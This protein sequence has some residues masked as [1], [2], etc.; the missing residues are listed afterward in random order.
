MQPA[1]GITALSRWHDDGHDDLRIALKTSAERVATH[2]LGPPNKCLSNRR[3]LRWGDT[4]RVRVQI[5]GRDAGRWIE[6]GNGG[7]KGD[8]LAM[9]RAHNPMPFA[10]VLA[11]TY[12]FVGLQPPSKQ[13]PV[14][15]RPVIPPKPVDPAI[16][17]EHLAD[18]A[19]RTAA[20]Q[21]RWNAGIPITGTIAET[22]LVATRGFPPPPAGW[23]SVAQL[24]YHPT[25]RALMAP[26]IGPNGT[27]QAVA[28]IYLDKNGQKATNRPKAKQNYGPMTDARI[29]LPGRTGPVNLAEGLETGLAAWLAT[30]CTTW[31]TC[32]T[33]TRLE[34]VPKW[35]VALEDDDN[36]TD[37]AEK[38]GVDTASAIAKAM[39][40]WTAAGSNVVIARPWP[41]RRYDG[42]DLA[43]VMRQHGP[44]AVK[45]RINIAV[46]PGVART[47]R[48]PVGEARK[49]LPSAMRP[50]FNAGTADEDP[51]ADPERP[52][53]VYVVHGS[54]GLGKSHETR[55]QIAD[56]INEMRRYGAKRTICVAVPRHDL[57]DQ[58][59]ERLRALDPNLY[60]EVWQ[61]RERPDPDQ[62]GQ[63]MCRDME[64][65]REAS[66]AQLDIDAYACKPC[67]HRASCGY[68]RQKNLQGVDVWIVAHS[69]L[70]NAK[71]AA[72]KHL[73]MLVIDENPLD[74]FLIGN[75][76]P[77][78]TLP[79]D[80]FDHVPVIEHDPIGTGELRELWQRAKRIV[81]PE[82]AEPGPLKRQAFQDGG[83]T[84][85][86][87]GNAELL[88][89]ATLYR[90]KLLDSMSRAER[91]TEIKYAHRNWDLMRRVAFWKAVQDL[92]DPTINTT[93][94]SGH[95][96]L[97]LSD[98]D[99]PRPVIVLKRRKAVP[100]SWRVPTLITTATLKL[101]LLRYVWPQIEVSA[102]VNITSPHTRIRQV[103][104]CSYSMSRLDPGKPEGSKYGV[105]NPKEAARR[106]N[107]RRDLHATIA[108][109]ARAVFPQKVLVVAQMAVEAELKALGW[110]PPN[111]CW[112]HHNAMTGLD[113]Y[114]DAR[115]IIVIGRTLPRTSAVE[116]AA[117]ALT[118]EAVEH[119]KQYDMADAQ[120]ETTE[121]FM[122]ATETYRHPNAIAEQFRESICE[123][124][125]I[126]IIGRGRGAD[127]TYADPL[128]VLV[129][130]D[131]PLD[132]PVAEFI[133]AESLEPSPWDLQFAAG[134]IAYESPA[135]AAKAYPTLWRKDRAAE[136]AFKEYRETLRGAN[137]VT[138]H[139]FPIENLYMGKL[140][141][142]L[143]LDFQNEG[144]GKRHCFAMVDLSLIES[145]HAAVTE[146]QGPIRE[147]IEH[148]ADPTPEPPPPKPAPTVK[149][150]LLWWDTDDAR[151]VPWWEECIPPAIRRM[152]E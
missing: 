92:L 45:A 107:R 15:P 137:D 9:I 50:A 35:C 150:G 8:L 87:A 149:L 4:G 86:D 97:A 118:G 101:D 60:V 55:N 48:I 80:A 28:Y 143:S 6:E 104:N 144:V 119:V 56:A 145:P 88:T 63:P 32:G 42:S 33:I 26:L 75:S 111:V 109:E 19:K 76:G 85:L 139:K 136:W 99:T 59:A 114:K 57:A 54:T 62:P 30:S 121:G 64:V 148:P 3:E 131:V 123:H 69:T 115:L 127:R 73:A 103:T 39:M 138:F 51:D 100:K 18:D 133:T 78:V 147:W 89:W 67:E 49:I 108:R 46:S 106:R 1:Q 130:T 90:P 84:R 152:L 10:D 31:I 27:V 112:G 38:K 151:T 141:K 105:L 126:Q 125:I 134:G 128:D 41:A 13:D 117:E 72:I 36:P 132:L 124:E 74:E 110:M 96:S 129:L 81:H 79:L 94:L 135:A 40:R 21:D 24:R 120:R 52:P 68:L 83:F 82:G 29:V 102:E 91:I 98:D 71:P 12:A 70:A 14:R 43:D 61:G 22:Y 7:R 37:T 116:N 20:A 113:D 146:H 44:A 2:I 142:V 47:Y 34:T 122:V 140:G 5:E 16:E 66:A 65:V 58:W 95:A 77:P 53:P 23:G 11:W 93:G 17:A 25:A